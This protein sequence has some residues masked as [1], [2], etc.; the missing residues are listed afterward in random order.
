MTPHPITYPQISQFT[1]NA[2]KWPVQDS[3][4]LQRLTNKKR[5]PEHGSALQALGLFPDTEPRALRQRND[6]SLRTG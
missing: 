4:K 2:T 3:S 1:P 5:E 6:T